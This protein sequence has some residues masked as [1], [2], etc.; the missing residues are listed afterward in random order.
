[1]DIVETLAKHAPQDC[2]DF[3]LSYTDLT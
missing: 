3:P 2:F 1:V